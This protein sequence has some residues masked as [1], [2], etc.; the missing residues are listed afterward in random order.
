MRNSLRNN[1][2][3]WKKR[4]EEKQQTNHKIDTVIPFPLRKE[5]EEVI[6]EKKALA[7]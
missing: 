3:A 1:Q 5:H 4:M 2:W 6:E 7:V